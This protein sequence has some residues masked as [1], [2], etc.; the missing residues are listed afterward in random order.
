VLLIADRVEVRL[1][2]RKKKRAKKE[3][4]KAAETFG[5]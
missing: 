5:V 3:E 1:R 2:G 4:K